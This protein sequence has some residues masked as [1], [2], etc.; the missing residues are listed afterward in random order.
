[1]CFQATAS[2]I[3][4]RAYSLNKNMPRLVDQGISS[5]WHGLAQLW[6]TAPGA[7]LERTCH[8]EIPAYVFPADICP[9]SWW[10]GGG[11][12][13]VALDSGWYMLLNCQRELS[14]CPCVKPG[15]Q[16]QRVESPQGGGG[17]DGGD[18]GRHSVQDGPL[19]SRCQPSHAAPDV[20]SS[21]RSSKGAA[22]QAHPKCGRTLQDI[23]LQGRL[24]QAVRARGSLGRGGNVQHGPGAP[25]HWCRQ[26]CTTAQPSHDHVLKA[27]LTRRTSQG[28]LLR[29]DL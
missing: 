23:A 24:H 6:A 7:G 20:R 4:A 5:R 28:K 2:S 8:H 19:L 17:D 25:R 26:C 18:H 13:G 29:P 1:M 22:H 14:A 21:I 15:S 9:G 12:G 16:L 10:G 11:G 3:I 27:H